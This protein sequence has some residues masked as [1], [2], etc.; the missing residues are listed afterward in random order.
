MSDLEAARAALRAKQGAGAR[1][2][3]DSAPHDALLLARRG[4]AVFAR[5]LNDLRDADLTAPARARIVA[6]VSYQARELA[7]ALSALRRPLAPEEAAWR[8]DVALATTLPARALRHLFD[9]AVKHLDVEWRDLP[10]DAW[11]AEIP[12]P[13]GR[14]ISARATPEMRAETVWRG[15]VELGNGLRWTDIPP[16]FRPE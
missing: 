4:T 14:R 16:H 5:K 3:A 15:A 9:H 1:Y 12:L 7:I 2:D 10:G 6:R 11:T 8:A 13:D